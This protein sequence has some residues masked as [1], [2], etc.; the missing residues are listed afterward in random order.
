MLKSKLILAAPALP[1]YISAKVAQA[2]K[3]Q[4]AALYNIQARLFNSNP[5]KLAMSETM[6][7]IRAALEIKDTA[8]N[9]CKKTRFVGNKASTKQQQVDEGSKAVATMI[10]KSPSKEQLM[11][12]SLGLKDSYSASSGTRS[13]GEDSDEG[14][15]DMSAYESRLAGSSDNDSEQEVSTQRPSAG[16]KDLNREPSKELSPSPQPSEFSESSRIVGSK[17]H[18]TASST[19]RS[20]TFE[21]SGNGSFDM[22]AYESRLADSSDNDS[23]QEESTQRPS[24]GNKGPNH[25]PPKELS[26]SPQPSEFSKS[27]QTVGSKQ[28]KTASSTI[29]STTFIPS[30]TMSGYISG[31][32]SDAASSSSHHQNTKPRKNRRGQQ[33][34]RQIWEKKYG[35]NA[36]HLKKSQKQSSST[37]QNRDQGWDARKGARADDEKGKRGNGRGNA[38]KE[39]NRPNRGGPTTSG[40][41]SD[42]VVQKRNNMDDKKQG[43][44]AKHQADRPLHP[45]WE[46]AKK[47][48]EAKK[49][50]KFQG[51]KVTFD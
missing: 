1:S 33:E 16:N 20:T 10:E 4:D 43:K 21:D 6:A 3:S 27:S 11:P 46:A 28:H 40:A 41:N 29:R 8:S 18:K 30:L 14:S 44:K 45:S 48:K 2:P 25:E 37:S 39:S 17:Q 7:L 31:S 34:R 5:V 26:L 42:P 47:A 23:E 12:A 24:A 36:N 15:F 38:R 22:S 51:K 32:D 9:G 35:K 49:N 19:T 50:V 13:E